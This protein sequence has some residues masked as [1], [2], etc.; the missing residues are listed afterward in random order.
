MRPAATA[1][2]PIS[3]ATGTMVSRS[4]GRTVT[5]MLKIAVFA[6]MPSANVRIDVA[7]NVLWRSNPRTA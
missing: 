3:S 1:T 7:A 5:T 2:A 6:P 4:G